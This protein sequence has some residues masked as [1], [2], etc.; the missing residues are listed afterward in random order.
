MYIPTHNIDIDYVSIFNGPF[1]SDV[2]METFSTLTIAGTNVFHPDCFILLHVQEITSET[3]EPLH[4][5]VSAGNEE[6]MKNACDR[7]DEVFN[8]PDLARRLASKSV[9]DVDENVL[10]CREQWISLP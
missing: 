4:I 10:M 9:I 2:E 5:V 8:K 7:I 3:D 6:A 1:K